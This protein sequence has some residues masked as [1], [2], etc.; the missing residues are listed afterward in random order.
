MRFIYW[1][2]EVKEKIREGLNY[3]IVCIC[4]CFICLCACVCVCGLMFI[5]VYTG[6][7][8]AIMQ[9]LRLKLIIYTN[10]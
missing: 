7:E 10:T 9:D 8:C 6:V 1:I 2:A 3:L 5:C 4:E